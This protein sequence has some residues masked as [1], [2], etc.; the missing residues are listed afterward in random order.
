MS[1]LPARGIVAVLAA[2]AMIVFLPGIA[3]ANAAA[4][5]STSGSVLTA[6]VSGV[7]SGESCVFRINSVVKYSSP[8]P[9]PSTL[10][11][12]YDFSG[13]SAGQYTADVQCDGGQGIY[14]T[15]GSTGV[16]WKGSNFGG[17]GTGAR[18]AVDVLVRNLPFLAPLFP[19]LQLD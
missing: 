11:Y 15:A 1:G 17:T 2:V 16:T 9:N 19:L 4:T 10:T 8:A 18:S 5:F 3:A 12:T 6:Q 7:A 14:Y 13:T